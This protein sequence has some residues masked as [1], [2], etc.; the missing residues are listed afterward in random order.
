MCAALA[1]GQIALPR[2]GVK[3]WVQ[4]EALGASAVPFL[5]MA[6]G[7]F[8]DWGSERYLASSSRNLWRAPGDRGAPFSCW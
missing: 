8:H 4:A 3:R 1:A 2:P 6:D 5:I 7:A